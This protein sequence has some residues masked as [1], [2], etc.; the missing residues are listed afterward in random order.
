MD[1]VRNKDF[2]DYIFDRVSHRLLVHKLPGCFINIIVN[3]YSKLYSTVR[4]NH[5]LSSTI[6]VNCGVRQGGILSPILFNVYDLIAIYG[7]VIDV[8]CYINSVF[9]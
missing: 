7:L 1:T 5:T 3:W 9:I 6:K 4:W 8:G 2:N